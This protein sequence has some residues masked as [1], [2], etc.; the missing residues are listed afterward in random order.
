MEKEQHKQQLDDLVRQKLSPMSPVYD[1]RS[2]ERL[3]RRL[4]Q[5]PLTAPE[6]MDAVIRERLKRVNTPY[7]RR[8]W[9]RLALQL[10]LEY[11]RT[12][13]VMRYKSMEMILA[14]LL[15]FVFTQWSL[16]TPTYPVLASGPRAVGTDWSV[17]LQPARLGS[18]SVM[19][20][21]LG[22]SPQPAVVLKPVVSVPV[23][24]VGS[25]PSSAG[26]ASSNTWPVAAANATY[27]PV[28]IQGSASNL[29]DAPRTT[30]TT[31]PLQHETA[32]TQVHSMHG[33]KVQPVKAQPLHALQAP[34]I[35]PIY[36]PDEVA[37]LSMP[38]KPAVKK[39]FLRV[40]FVGGPDYNRIIT[41]PTR[42]GLNT[43]VALDRYS[44]GYHGG[45]T[46]G[47]EK[48]RWEIETGAIYAARSYAPVPVLYVSGSLREGY[49]GTGLNNFELN[50]VNLPLGLRY[51]IIQRDK[52]RVYA[53]GGIALNIILEANY[54]TASESAYSTSFQRPPSS[55]GSGRDE[56]GGIPSSL[57]RQLTKGWLQGGT[58]WENTTIYTNV[59]GGL[60]RYMSPRWAL[61]SQTVYQHSLFNFDGGLGPYQDRIHS[62]SIMLGVKVR[63]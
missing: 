12:Q 52:W 62:M 53:L 54:Y 11:R 46:L 23:A 63:L 28:Y 4:D 24:A 35:D 29:H 42:L 26:S 31:A 38:L 50:T 57:E 55:D 18:T 5:E 17:Q 14:L 41:P 27:L 30:S 10:E 16:N 15:L 2:W 48:D 19:M 58:F 56:S 43:V 3:S 20:E 45:I 59:G 25:Q 44:L 32:L 61:F 13:A 22:C 7:Q 51:N 1:P 6:A 21:Q 8:S 33:A 37:A 47:V 36:H 49:F 34:S 9:Q 60:E 40:G 39:T